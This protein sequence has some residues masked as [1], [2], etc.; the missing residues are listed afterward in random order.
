MFPQT[1][2]VNKFISLLMSV[3]PW[4]VLAQVTSVEITDSWDLGYIGCAQCTYNGVTGEFFNTKTIALPGRGNNSWEYTVEEL[5]EEKVDWPQ[6]L[7]ENKLP[8]SNELELNFGNA[9]LENFAVIRYNPLVKRNDGVYLITRLKLGFTKT[10][11][12]TLA[13]D[14]TAT[15]ASNSV[16]KTGGWYKFGVSK[17]GVQKLDVEFLTSLGINVSSL[18]PNH[19]NIYGNHTPELPI[20]NNAYHPDDLLKNAIYIEGDGDNVFNASDYILFY[21]TGPE[22]LNYSGGYFNGGPAEHDSLVYYFIRID[23]T[24]SPKRINNQSQSVG[25]VTNTVY[26]G[27]EYYFHELDEENLLKSGDGW[28]GEHFDVELIKNVELNLEGLSTSDSL[29]ANTSFVSERQTGTSKLIVRANGTQIQELNEVSTSSTYT[30]A[31]RESGSTKFKVNSSS[32]NFEFEYQRST[33][34][35]EAWLDYMQLNYIRNY[36]VTTNQFIIHD[37]NTVGAG[38]VTNFNISNWNSLTKVWEVT[39]PVNVSNQLGTVAGSTFNFTQDTD[40]LRSFVVFRQDQAFQPTAIGP[41]NNQNLHSLSQADFI[42][43]SH[44]TLMTQAERLANLHRADGLTVH[45]VDVAK[46]YNEFGGGAADPVSI[47]WFMKMFYDRAGGDPTLMPKYLC[48]FGDGTYDP[49]NRIDDNNYLIPTYRNPETGNVNFISSYT[50]DDFFA[51]LD[52]G[53]AMGAWDLMDVA[54]GRIPVDNIANAEEVVDKIEHYKNF[55]SYLYANANGVQCNDDG[56]SSS[57][58]DWRNRIVLIADDKD[59]SFDN[60]VPDCENLSDTTRKLHPEMNIIKIYADAYQQV[61]TSGGQRYPDVEEALNQNMGRGALVMN[62]VGHGGETG[63][64]QER[65]LDIPMIEGWT[66]IN[67]LTVFISATCEFTRFDD[68]SRRSAGE[69][70]LVSPYGAS[71]AMLTTTR[72]VDVNVNSQLVKNLYTVLF[73][74]ENGKPLSIGE[75]TR[76]TKNLTAGN[77][78]MR[79]FSMMGDPALLLGKPSPFIVTDSINGV[80]IAAPLDTMKALSKITVSGHV[81]DYNGNLQSTYNGLVFPTVYDKWKDRVTLGQ[82]FGTVFDFDLQNNI[83]YKGKASVKNGFFQFT[84][85]VPKDI[86]Y[87]FGKGKISY[88]AH[89]EVTQQYGWDTSVVVGGVDPNGIND[90]E[91]PII[92]LYMNDENFVFGGMTNSQPMFLAH[93]EDE[94]GINTTGNGIGHN[95]T[96]VLDGNTAESIILNNYYEADLDTYKSGK[97]NYQLSE[98]SP[99]P[100]SITFKVWDVNNN[101]SEETLEFIV[102]EEEEPSISHLLNYPNPFTTNTS[103]YFEHN[104]VCSN[105]QVQLEIFTVSGKLVKTIQRNVMTEG[106]RSEG[107]AWDGLDEYGDKLGKGVYVYR[108]S[109]TTPDGK[110]AEKLEKLVI[111]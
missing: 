24:D 36:S 32:V 81:E 104:Q 103:F 80:S 62:Y 61:T 18:N 110:K 27:T 17:T 52:D 35:N 101:S 57:L 79:N 66:N 99:G 58:G 9:G 13:H 48:L 1:G 30:V 106:F 47:R 63:L 12:Y 7:D 87:N 84:F 50:S 41:I 72:L 25:A 76:R 38:E 51:M 33:P 22:E 69:L 75:I 37:L 98:L 4:S 89:N 90:T 70:M 97:V 45:V 94:N 83:I 108:L 53:E 46:V 105:L 91:G 96:M 15:F 42:I 59:K 109:F 68:P 39:D 64:A 11:G 111:L 82:D 10:E 20:A 56:Y 6:Y 43:V 16:L 8:I 107:I 34:A 40:S 55:G 2:V 102:V 88:Y 92:D 85:I 93:I 78:N 5:V 44:S 49:L 95:I 31:V 21:A 19:L 74:E 29:R 86:D 14:R 54:V 77:E 3:L 65:I 28:F 67:N 26:K 73:L 100:H 23:N 71:V 60:F